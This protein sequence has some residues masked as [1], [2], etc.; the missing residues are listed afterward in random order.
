MYVCTYVC[1]VNVKDLYG[2]KRNKYIGGRLRLK[3][4]NTIKTMIGSYTCVFEY[5][6]RYIGYIIVDAS[7]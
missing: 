1:R 5:I 7:I 2:Q 6:G 3:T 4:K